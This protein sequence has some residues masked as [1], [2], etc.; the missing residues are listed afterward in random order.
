MRVCNCLPSRDR[1]GVGSKRLFQQSAKHLPEEERRKLAGWFEGME[2]AAWD[3]EMERDFASGGK[4]EPL[5]QEIQREICEG[6]ARPLE[7]GLAKRRHSPFATFRCA[8]PLSVLGSL[9]DRLPAVVVFRN[10]RRAPFC[11]SPFKGTSR[12]RSLGSSARVALKENCS[13]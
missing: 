8:D 6:K 5:A 10:S 12:A 7:E 13:R 2:E 1:E 9:Y 11:A 3:E 4:G